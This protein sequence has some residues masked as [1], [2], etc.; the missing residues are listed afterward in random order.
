MAR[1]SET[2][3]VILEKPDNIS[4]PI[5]GPAFKR[6]DTELMEQ[7]YEVSSATASATLHRIGIRQSYMHGPLPRVAGAKVVGPAVTLQFMPQREDI[8][9]GLGQEQTEKR[10]ALW[11]VF[12][13]VEPGDVIVVQAWADPYTGC[14]GDMLTTYFKG[15]GGIGVVVDGCVRDWPKIQKLDVPM[16][17]V[18]VTPKP[19]NPIA[20]YAL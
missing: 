3:N 5:E 6:P 4:L 18:G 12:D 15:R 9:S 1:P 20:L 13:S 11:S 2:F 16:W 7:L 14:R 10:S 19:Q 17:T 8:A